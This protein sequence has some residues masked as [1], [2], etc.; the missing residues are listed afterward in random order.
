[1]RP[2]ITALSR[3][4][5]RGLLTLLA[6]LALGTFAAQP[7]LDPDA[8]WHLRVADWTIAHGG[9][10]SVDVV[11]YLRAGSGWVAHSW[12][13]EL[14]LRA[15]VALLGI[16]GIA[17]A[18]IPAAALLAW[19]LLRL[20][21]L[22]R[23]SLG[24]PER[25]LA[26]AVVFAALRPVL[27][28]RA[29]LVDAV[30]AAAIWYLIE[31]ARLRDDRQPLLLLPLITVLWA[32]LHGAGVLLAP[33]MVLLFLAATRA[34][35]VPARV[36]RGDLARLGAAMTAAVCLNPY[37]PVLLV[38]PFATLGSAA[39]RALIAEWGPTPI[40]APVFA[41]VGLLL[42]ALLLALPRRGRELPATA[43]LLLTV[44]VVMGLGS[45]RWWLPLG[46]LAAAAAAPV[47][48][49]G[50]AEVLA[51]LR[52]RARDEQARGL[53][54][55]LRAA[56]AGTVIATIAAAR[57]VSL[58]PAV[59]GPMVAADFPVGA[60]DA[61]V[62]APCPGGRLFSPYTWGGYLAY[63]TGEMVGP[64]GAADS[65]G[66]ALIVEQQAILEGRI[67]PGP[68]FARDG[69]DRAVI[70]AGIRLAEDLAAAGWTA[71]AYDGVLLMDRSGGRCAP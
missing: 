38:Y 62:A 1:M 14:W 19:L 4:D 34:A 11:S 6:C 33:G 63:R 48:A 70:P 21:A 43:P 55:R 5:R 59:M 28:A 53:P 47:V 36:R 57:L 18:G 40:T 10:P 60:A 31:R 58:T 26:V 23:P 45:A 67:A 35:G 15:C 54:L 27:Y 61:A 32:N 30:G 17:V 8:F 24:L 50:A 39:Q 12:L 20:S 44:T 56:V 2:L 29:G 42:A 68:A 3:V 64:Y 7:Q 51:L 52:G 46:P 16:A 66:D 13:Y 65:L 22:Y 9:P 49:V 71:R 69:V 25:L 37:G 41:A